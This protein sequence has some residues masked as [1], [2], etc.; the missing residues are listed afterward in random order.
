[1]TLKQQVT[2]TLLK[3]IET[4]EY[5]VGELLP[6]EIDLQEIHGVSRITIRAA[7]S[8]LELKGYIERTKG[9]GTIVKAS[10]IAEPLLKIEGFTEEMKQVG[11]IPTTKDARISLIEAD[12]ECSKALGIPLGTKVYE[13][14]RV[15]CINKVP[16][17]IFRTYLIS[18]IPMSLNNEMY[19]HSLYEYMRM[20][21]GIN[22]QRVKQTISASVTDENMA[23]ILNCKKNEA[24]LILK[25]IGYEKEKETPIEYTIAKYV[26]SR[27][28]YYFELER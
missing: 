18:D 21:H 9:K 12:E 14:V 2:E 19:Q 20:K 10:K 22:I 17:A 24:I 7:L 27:Y 25:R 11:I 16:V 26:G 4:G 13:L 5:E 28:E 1:M 23:F 8:E 3:Q 6:R 15:R